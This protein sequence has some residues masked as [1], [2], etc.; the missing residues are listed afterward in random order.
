MLRNKKELSTPGRWHI[1]TIFIVR[2]KLKFSS[3]FMAK[4]GNPVCCSPCPLPVAGDPGT[5]SWAGLSSVLP[6][7][8]EAL[9]LNLL[10]TQCMFTGAPRLTMFQSSP[11]D[12]ELQSHKEERSG[13]GSRF[14]WSGSTPSSMSAPLRGEGALFNLPPLPPPIALLGKW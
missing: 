12:T 3:I 13:W 6:P 7:K 1:Y 8:T 4:S 10:Q 5:G 2:V 11:C 14:S 9:F